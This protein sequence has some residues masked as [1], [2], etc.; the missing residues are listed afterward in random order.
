MSIKQ[1]HLPTPSFS[2]GGKKIST[3]LLTQRGGFVLVHGRTASQKTAQ[4][5]PDRGESL[6]EA[7]SAQRL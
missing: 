6:E 3:K 7:S 4:L 5:L 2:V 1:F